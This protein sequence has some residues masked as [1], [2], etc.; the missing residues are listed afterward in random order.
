[1]TCSFASTVWSTG[2]QFTLAV[3]RVDEPGVE[4]VEEHPLLVLVIGRVAGRELARPVERQPHR[5]ELRP[6]RV[7]VLVGPG[8]GVDLVLHRGVLGRHAEGVPAHRMQDVEAAG[9]LVARDDVAHG[10]VAHMAHVDAPRRIGEHLQHVVFRARIVVPGAEQVF[11]GPDRL[12]FRLGFLGVVALGSH[13]EVRWSCFRGK[14]KAAHAA[15]RA[16]T[17]PWMRRA[18]Q[19]RISS[20][21]PNQLRNR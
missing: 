14:G 4:E 16:R 18:G 19:R 17:R 1:M 9:A 5:L 8:L 7:D 6:H 20:A 13:R 10:V 15:E 3:L 21:V 2:S 12:P 11:L